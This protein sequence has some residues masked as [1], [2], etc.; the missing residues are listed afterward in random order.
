M[1]IIICSE[2]VREKSEKYYNKFKFISGN[3]ES[4]NKIEENYAQ[5]WKVTL[6][7]MTYCVHDNFLNVRTKLF[8]PGNDYS[9]YKDKKQSSFY[10]TVILLD[11]CEKIPNLS[12]Q[13]TCD[14]LCN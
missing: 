6:S 5:S 2:S 1:N 13:I 4:E 10:K 3:E 14:L 8:I 9:N 7:K 12:D 11:S